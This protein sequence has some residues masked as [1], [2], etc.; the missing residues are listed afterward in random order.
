MNFLGGNDMKC[1]LKRLSALLLCL[2]VTVSML[3]GVVSAKEILEPKKKCAL[4]M[5]LSCPGKGENAKAEPLAGAKVYLYRIATINFNKNGDQMFYLNPKFIPANLNLN[6]VKTSEDYEKLVKVQEL[7]DLVTKNQIRPQASAVSDQNGNVHFEKQRCGIYM[8]RLANPQQV[9]CTMNE[10]LVTLPRVNNGNYD[11][12]C[13]Q[14][15]AP[16]TEIVESLQN[17]KVIK[18]W[19]NDQ[20]ANRPASIEVELLA[21]GKL[22]DGCTL[23]AAN[24]WTHIFLD[25]PAGPNWKVQ[26]KVPS[27]YKATI[28]GP[29]QEK[30]CIVFTITNTLIPNKPLIQT[31]QLNWPVPVLAIAGSL[32]ILYGWGICHEKKK[33]Q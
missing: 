1:N 9:H 5:V 21:D 31:G 22:A 24:S 4:N 6:K 17:I 29:A 15:M 33:E 18:E 19:K 30:D 25:K 32:L 16:K 10:F 20:P 14:A 8:I 23:N 7:M 27:G 2:M 3:A 13:T 11:Y 12:D 28:S 26:E